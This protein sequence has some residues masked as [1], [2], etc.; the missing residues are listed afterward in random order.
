[1]KKAHSLT[2]QILGTVLLLELVSATVLIGAS[3]AY[4][5]HSRLSAF[6][7]MLR[8]QADTLLGAV[9][10][11]DDKSDD[12]MLDTRG[13][14]IPNRDLYLIRDDR[15]GILGKS[16]SPIPKTIIDE[17][18]ATNKAIAASVNGHYYRFI[19]LSGTRIV[20]PGDVGGGVRH[21][22][23]I[24]YGAR[25]NH[26][27][28]EAIE[29]V[30]FYIIATIL[31]FSITT[32]VMIWLLRRDLSP[33]HELARE[34]ERVSPKDWTFKAP[35]GAKETKELLPLAAAIES[36]LARLR[37]SF[38]QQK[39]LI[40]DAAH[41][42]KTDASIAKSSLQL[43]AMR[44]RTVNEY[45]RGLE[46]CLD[47]Y[48][49]MER[50]V[51]QMLTLARAEHVEPRAGRDRKKER[52]S[53]R[54]SL[55][56]SIR[57]MASLAE[58]RGVKVCLNTEQ[59]ALVE[60]DSGDCNHLFS[61]LF[62]NALQHSPSRSQVDASL[63]VGKGRAMVQIRDRGE[64]IAVDDLPY[65]FEPFY[66]GDPSRSRE[67]GGTGLGLAICKALCEAHGGTIRIENAIDGGALVTVEVPIVD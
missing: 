45:Q 57:Q 47:D 60:I 7:V 55:Q 56:S 24:V 25:T 46:L 10:D 51:Q 19:Y 41:E 67:S 22:L 40:S 13:L 50:T 1:M 9:G 37:R 26:I 11:A 66:R 54:S 49:R 58:L 62:L 27:W 8:G 39:R 65:L 17:A 30:R 23:T 6:D 63:I 42:L 32:L 15:S 31:L 21:T 52:S 5:W 4:E 35:Q 16:S 43:L 14:T 48:A 20:D 44:P 2:R 59:D 3:V 38:E 64:G 18:R 28:H 34:A 53:L 61:N 12:V 36:T 29:A 33:L